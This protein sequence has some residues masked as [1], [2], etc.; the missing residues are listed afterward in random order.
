MVEFDNSIS[1]VATVVD[2]HAPDT[3]GLLFRI[4]QALAEFRLDILSATVQT[5]G[6]EAV[7]S[8]YLCDRRGNKLEDPEV[9]RDLELAIR[10]AMG[11]E[12]S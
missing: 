3:I 5:L 12:E 8:F 1:D 11:D 10:G 6:P 9:L 2:V 4:T 7:D